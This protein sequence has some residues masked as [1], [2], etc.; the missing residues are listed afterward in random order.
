MTDVDKQAR[1]ICRGTGDEALKRLN[2]SGLSED[3]D[4]VP[5]NL[6]RFWRIT[7]AEC[8][9][10]NPQNAL[11][12]KL[13]SKPKRYSSWC[14]CR[15]MKLWSPIRS[16]CTATLTWSIIHWELKANHRMLCTTLKMR[17]PNLLSHGQPTFL[18]EY[19]CTFRKRCGEIS[20]TLKKL[21]ENTTI[22]PAYS[23]QEIICLHTIDFMPI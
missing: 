4:K 19:L 6:W 9:L 23:S 17:S 7:E 12:N 2:A 14:T 13:S 16:K 10:L 18:E 15:R 20:C 1:R 8:T 11:R 5:G 22:L 3:E 21:E